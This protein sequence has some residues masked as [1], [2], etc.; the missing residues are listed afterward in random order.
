[1][2]GKNQACNQVE[3]NQRS[4]CW[5]RQKVT[6]NIF[7]QISLDPSAHDSTR[8]ESWTSMDFMFGAEMSWDELRFKSGR[9]MQNPKKWIEHD[10]VERV[11]ACHDL[12]IHAEWSC[13]TC[14]FTSLNILSLSPWCNCSSFLIF[15]RMCVTSIACKLRK[16]VCSPASLR[17]SDI[18][19][20]DEVWFRNISS[21][22][23]TNLKQVAQTN[24]G[25][26][27]SPQ[28]KPSS[29]AKKDFC[30]LLLGVGWE[31]GS[32]FMDDIR[33]KTCVYTCKWWNDNTTW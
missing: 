15:L 25:C 26:Q 17:I 31:R 1:M 19:D 5:F 8:P 20:C 16:I 11:R 13:G 9:Q 14:V 12:M 30:D 4:S 2:R 22:P 3:Q 32:D 18:K 6:R 29:V 7:R 10:H 27:K 23:L 28:K 24:S 21:V 33:Q